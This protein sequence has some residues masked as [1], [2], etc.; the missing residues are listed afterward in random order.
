MNQQH[1]PLSMISLNP[2]LHD[3]CRTPFSWNGAWGSRVGKSKRISDMHLATIVL[4][5]VLRPPL[6]FPASNTHGDSGVTFSKVM[7]GAASRLKVTNLILTPMQKGR[8]G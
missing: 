8:E 5:P 6:S 4:I 3:L 7:G 1:L 2:L